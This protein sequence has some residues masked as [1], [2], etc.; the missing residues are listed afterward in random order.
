MK[1]TSPN[2]THQYKCLGLFDPLLHLPSSSL[3]ATSVRLTTWCWLSRGMLHPGIGA[4]TIQISICLKG[5][6]QNIRT[7]I[8]F[9]PVKEIF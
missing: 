2:D 7:S 1:Y 4:Y 8:E 6:S 5:R 3:Y 9:L